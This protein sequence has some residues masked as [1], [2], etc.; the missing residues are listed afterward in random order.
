MKMKKVVAKKVGME[1]KKLMNQ[2][3]GLLVHDVD[4]IGEIVRRVEK[5]L[6]GVCTARPE[7]PKLLTI[8]EQLSEIH[9]RLEGVRE[10]VLACQ[11]QANG[12]VPQQEEID[13]WL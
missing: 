2:K 13:V 4:R 9:T 10:F 7:D 3:I 12:N 5:E 1:P 6:N 8:K 11:L